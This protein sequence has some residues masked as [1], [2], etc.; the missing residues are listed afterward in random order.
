MD[1]WVSSSP[2]CTV[3]GDF[4][5]HVSHTPP[6]T[7]ELAQACSSHDNGISTEETYNWGLGLKLV[8]CHCQLILL[9]TASHMTEHRIKQWTNTL[10]PFL[11]H[12]KIHFIFSWHLVFQWENCCQSNCLFFSVTIFLIFLKDLPFLSD[13]F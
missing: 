10:E 9:T 3:W 11:L 8:Y 5:P 6:G 4:L 2:T 7:T 13:T 12:L 1:L